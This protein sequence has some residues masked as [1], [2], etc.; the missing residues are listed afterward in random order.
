MK[1]FGI[2]LGD[3]RCG[4]AVCDPSE[5]LATPYQTLQVRGLKDAL[6]QLVPLVQK[7]GVELVVVGLPLKTD[8]TRGER[9]ERSS[10]F[11][12]MLRSV[13]EVPVV[14][15][16]ERF[17]TVEAYNLLH[18]VGRNHKN[19]RRDVDALAATLIL[20]SYLDSRK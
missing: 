14:S 8:G 7:E 11:C 4:V 16:D 10:A 2:D 18:E 3:R 17:S 12:E 20:Q 9:A 5:I 1:I 15:W 6:T 13:T 19:S